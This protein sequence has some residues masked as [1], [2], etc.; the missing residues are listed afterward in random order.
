MTQFKTDLELYDA[1]EADQDALFDSHFDWEMNST[2]PELDNHD[3]CTD[4]DKTRE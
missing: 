4:K 2:V 3:Y 1:Y